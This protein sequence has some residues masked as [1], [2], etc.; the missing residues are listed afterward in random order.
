MACII[1][2]TMRERPA[3]RGLTKAQTKAAIQALGLTARWSPEWGEWRVTVPPGSMS[4][5]KRTDDA[6]REAVAIYTPDSDDALDSARAM[7][8]ELTRNPPPGFR[9]PWARHGQ[10]A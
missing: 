4:H 8:A 7:R 6:A 1:N 10:E 3:P 5:M 2:V 9:S